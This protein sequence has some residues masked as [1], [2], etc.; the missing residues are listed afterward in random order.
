MSINIDAVVGSHLAVRPDGETGSEFVNRWNNI[1]ANCDYIIVFGGTNDVAPTTP[2]G[3]ETDNVKTTIMGALNTICTNLINKAP[4]AK[5]LFITPLNFIN[6]ARVLQI[7]DAIKT[8]CAKYSIP[9]LDL[10]AN[11]NYAPVI[12]SQLLVYGASGTDIY[13]P[14]VLYHSHLSILVEKAL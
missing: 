14:N 11:G 10:Y 7:I 5:I 4:T 3:I 6:N 8:I 13:H 2:I 12:N 1:D 9:V